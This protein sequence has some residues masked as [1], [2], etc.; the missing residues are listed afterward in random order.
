MAHPALRPLQNE[1]G[2]VLVISII[3][4]MLLTLIGISIT[5][6]TSIELQIAGNDKIQKATFSQADGGTE[7]AA[8][9]IEQN[10]GC[11]SGFGEN[12]INDKIYV[13]NLVFWQNLDADI[14]NPYDD[15]DPNFPDFYFPATA[16]TLPIATVDDQRVDVKVGGNTTLST[17]AAIQ[18][19]AGYEGK[20]KAAG[21]G[22]GYILYDIYSRAQGLKNSESIIRMQW[23]H[24]IGTE[25]GCNF[26]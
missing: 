24:I 19:V 21:G 5:T 15:T 7:V 6:T 14:P 17:G 12:A 9:L 26:P 1:K 22:G 13:N 8:E 20:G 3:I 10:L 25:G 2:F 4:L 18:M 16:T 23:R 11:M